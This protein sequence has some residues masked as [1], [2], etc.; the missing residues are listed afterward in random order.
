MLMWRPVVHNA[1]GLTATY[2][3]CKH[4]NFASL[5]NLQ[6]HTMCFFSNVTF[7][8]ILKVNGLHLFFLTHSSLSLLS[9]NQ[10]HRQP[11][12]MNITSKIIPHMNLRYVIPNV[13][14]MCLRIT[15]RI[16]PLRHKRFLT[17][18]TMEEVSD[19]SGCGGCWHL[20]RSWW[21]RLTMVVVAEVHNDDNGGKSKIKSNW[22]TQW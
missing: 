3:V 18:A 15:I 17:T 13:K 16:I 7:Y 11:Q 8:S 21:R 4:S 14:T 9:L 10:L 22:W 2:I 6:Q 20:R 12:S 5:W 1:Y 19:D